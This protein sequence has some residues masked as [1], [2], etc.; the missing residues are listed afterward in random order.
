MGYSPRGCKESDTTERLH[1]HFQCLLESVPNPH[2]KQA[3]SMYLVCL[4]N[5]TEFGAFLV[6]QMVKNLLAVQKT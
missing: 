6:A 2:G 5:I 3:L 4:K 1:F